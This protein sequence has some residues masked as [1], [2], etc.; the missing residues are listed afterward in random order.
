LGFCSLKCSCC[1]LKAAEQE[2]RKTETLLDDARKQI[3]RLQAVN[4]ERTNT[5]K[6]LQKRLLLVS[7]VSVHT[8]RSITGCHLFLRSRH[9]L[10]TLAYDTVLSSLEFPCIVPTKKL[11]QE[12]GIPCCLGDIF[13]CVSIFF[14]R[15]FFTPCACNL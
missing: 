4:D 15:L 8:Q 12:E 13:G 2:K 11:F 7:Y 3:A 5:F 10:G 6:R 9:F 1:R 14:K